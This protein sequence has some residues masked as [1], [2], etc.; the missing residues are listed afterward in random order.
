VGRLRLEE[1]LPSPESGGSG[2]RRQNATGLDCLHWGLERA[3]KVT[4]RS[5]LPFFRLH[6]GTPNA[7]E[8]FR[9]AVETPSLASLPGTRRYPRVGP[10]C[11]P[12]WHAPTTT[13]PRSSSEVRSPER[14][15]ERD[16]AGAVSPRQRG[17]VV[18]P[19][20]ESEGR[21]A[22]GGELKPAPP[23]LRCSCSPWI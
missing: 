21:A 12:P 22:V 20:G 16:G 17:V 4:C 8:W 2:G 18:A 10:I 1:P 5:L 6:R 3:A 13:T 15:R 7:T 9:S 23:L 19:P 14:E 11:L